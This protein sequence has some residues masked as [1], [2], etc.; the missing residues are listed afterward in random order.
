M[1]K[2]ESKKSVTKKGEAKT[3]GKKQA[4]KKPIKKAKTKVK[5]HPGKK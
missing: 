5:L 2:K 4:S 3:K 1:G